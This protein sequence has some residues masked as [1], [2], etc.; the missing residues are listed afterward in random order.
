MHF[1]L[2][3][4]KMYKHA[5]LQCFMEDLHLTIRVSNSARSNIILRLPEAKWSG[6]GLSSSK[7]MHFAIF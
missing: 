3:S 5:C 2:K 1:W 7:Y 4:Y 6:A